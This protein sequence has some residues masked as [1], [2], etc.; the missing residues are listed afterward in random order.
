MG[1]YQ[2]FSFLWAGWKYRHPI[3][4]LTRRRIEAR[5]R[6]SSLG[7]LWALLHPLLMLGIYTFV[8]SFVFRLR[9]GAAEADRSEFALFLFS[10][11]IVYGIF[12]ECVNQ[13]PSLMIANQ[14]Y[15]KQLIFPSEI[16]AWTIL[17]AAVFNFLVSLLL[18]FA[19]YTAILG[20]PPVSS[21]WLP[22]VLA[23]VLL[24][25]L[26]AVWFLSSIGVFMRDVDQVVGVLTTAL[27]FLSPIFYPSSAI[28]LELRQWYYLNPFASLLDMCRDSLFYGAPP[29]WTTL[30]ILALAGWAIAWLGYIWFMKTKKGFSDVL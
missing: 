12:A 30:G 22:L 1:L 20:V 17:V 21:L 13:A 7:L 14:V 19:F 25:T 4:Q 9:W 28:P 6:G 16:L 23:P 5:Y 10:G 18:F 29:D 8:F 27:L 26:G 11:M 2:P 3:A 24:A 15:I